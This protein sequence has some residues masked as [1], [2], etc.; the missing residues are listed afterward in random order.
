M[1]RLGL[2]VQDWYSGWRLADH[3][4]RNA[5]GLDQSASGLDML[6]AVIMFDLVHHG[7]DFVLVLLLGVRCCLRIPDEEHRAHSVARCFVVI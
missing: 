1:L 4:A 7:V 6:V 3:L 2:Q 5:L